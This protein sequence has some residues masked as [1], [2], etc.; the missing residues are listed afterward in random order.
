MLLREIYTL[1]QKY[2]HM[3]AC[4]HARTHACTQA[5]THTHTLTEGEC[6]GPEKSLRV[7]WACREWSH[8]AYNNILEEAEEGGRVGGWEGERNIVTEKPKVFCCLL[9]WTPSYPCIVPLP[10]TP[11]QTKQR[12]KVQQTSQAS[13][14][15]VITRY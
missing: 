10:C 5:R 9:L 12:E 14:Q 11:W 1:I 7:W 3:R 15:L 13:S 6:G 2:T 8:I 4:V